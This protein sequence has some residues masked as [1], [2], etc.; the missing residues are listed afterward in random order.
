METIQN[1]TQ[2]INSSSHTPHNR[3]EVF[4]KYYPI[5]LA[6]CCI[7]FIFMGKFIAVFLIFIGVLTLIETNKRSLKEALLPV[8]SMLHP[9]LYLYIA[10]SGIS[11]LWSVAPLVTLTHTAKILLISSL[12]FLLVYKIGK[13]Q[14]NL[15]CYSNRL[16]YLLI[17]LLT[18]FNLLLAVEHTSGYSLTIAINNFIG[19]KPNLR[20]PLDRVSVL[21]LMSLPAYLYA[22]RTK[23]WARYLVVA[24]TLFNYIIHPMDAAKVSLLAVTSCFILYK[25]TGRKIISLLSYVL[26]ITFMVLPLLFMVI[27]SS[28]QVR[29]YLLSNLPKSWIERIEMWQDCL[30]FIKDKVIIGWGGGVSPELIDEFGRP[31]LQRHPH[32]GFIQLWTESGAVGVCIACFILLEIFQ[33]IKRLRSEQEVKSAVLLIA[34]YMPIFAFSYSTWQTWFISSLW[35]AI[36]AWKTIKLSTTY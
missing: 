26:V 24:L 14:I 29:T 1:S 7:P 2:N 28:Y 17:I 19:L 16:Q 4:Y 31:L 12:G 8:G 3:L 35:L 18:V 25:F 36:V 30:H 34:A 21:Y 32:N 9:L 5:I 11:C 10:W 20:Q 6:G 13:Y 23:K 33:Q 22:L 15:R 27:L